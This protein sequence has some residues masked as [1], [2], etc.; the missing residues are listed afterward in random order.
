MKTS[1]TPKRIVYDGITELPIINIHRS[2]R[3]KVSRGLTFP[4]PNDFRT[5][6]ESLIGSICIKYD[7]GT[8]TTL[9]KVSLTNNYIV[10]PH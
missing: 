2:N 6:L 1:L 9:P 8:E 4:I 5:S 10:Q 3:H 7:V